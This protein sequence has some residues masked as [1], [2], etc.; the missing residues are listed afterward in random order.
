MPA[1]TWPPLLVNLMFIFT[2]VSISHTQVGHIPSQEFPGLVV[3]LQYCK[4]LASQCLREAPE[5]GHCPQALQSCPCQPYLS[6][7]QG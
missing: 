4:R 1:V 5:R 3:M 7:W 6:T 2:V